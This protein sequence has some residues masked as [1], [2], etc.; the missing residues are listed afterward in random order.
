M[1]I[2]QI[3]FGTSVLVGDALVFS[4][5]I[6]RGKYESVHGVVRFDS[7]DTDAGSTVDARVMVPH[8]NVLFINTIED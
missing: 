6:E 5:S 2:S 4:V 7:W 8:S 3:V 1:A